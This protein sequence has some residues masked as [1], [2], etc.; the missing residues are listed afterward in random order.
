M[1]R[2]CNSILFCIIMLMQIAN[3]KELNYS[4]EKVFSFKRIGQVIPSPDGKSA[5]FIVKQLNHETHK[6]NYFLYLKNSN[7]ESKIIYNNTQSIYS[8]R[9]SADGKSIGYIAPGKKFDS[10]WVV[11]IDSL[12]P[13]KSIEYVNDI[14]SF[15]WSPDQKSFAFLSKDKIIVLIMS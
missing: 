3:A 13:Y 11:N 12:K 7:K 6:W 10:I 1:N 2:I 9:W 4:S 8:P 15:Q 5:V 14:L